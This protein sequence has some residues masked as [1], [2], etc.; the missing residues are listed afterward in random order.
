MR[1]R[2]SNAF[3][4]LVQIK[5]P[6][7]LRAPDLK[8]FE[9]A[10]LTWMRQN[11]IARINATFSGGCDEGVVD[12]VTVRFNNGRVVRAEDLPDAQRNRLFDV[13]E[14]VVAKKYEGFAGSFSVSGKV[15]LTPNG[16]ASFSGTVYFDKSKIVAHGPLTDYISSSGFQELISA[17][18][19]HK[20]SMSTMTRDFNEDVT[21]SFWAEP[22]CRSEQFNR[23]LE[24]LLNEVCMALSDKINGD[25]A[26][27]TVRVVLRDETLVEVAEVFASVCVVTECNVDDVLTMG[28][29]DDS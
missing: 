17:M 29:T 11:S 18:V 28:T 2:K 20:V 4:Q 21:D 10:V 14:Y 6:F 5:V 7:P 13:M 19:E 9:N 16:K 22:R 8:T 15:T 25:T 27:V 23:L 12:Y 24:R 26:H 3:E 1:A